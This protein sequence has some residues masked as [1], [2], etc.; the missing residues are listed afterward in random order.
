M[1][2]KKMGRP[3]DSVKNHE[4]KARIDDNLYRDLREYAKK[5]N[6]NNAQV[7]RMALEL[8]FSK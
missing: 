8:L 1:E 5:N 3:T 2:K 6:L 4:I 7:I